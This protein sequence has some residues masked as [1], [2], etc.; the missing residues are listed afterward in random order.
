[1]ESNAFDSHRD[2]GEH[3]TFQYG[4]QDPLEERTEI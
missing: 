4:R 2:N 1:M 3:V